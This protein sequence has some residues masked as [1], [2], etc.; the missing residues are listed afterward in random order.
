MQEVY[1]VTDLPRRVKTLPRDRKANSKDKGSW[2]STQLGAEREKGV[3]RA[4]PAGG[5]TV[6]SPEEG[7]A[8][9]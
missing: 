2:S 5:F 8:F 6:K 4:R 9:M 1:E 3:C 7:G